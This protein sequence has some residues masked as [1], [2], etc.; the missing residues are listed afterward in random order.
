[1]GNVSN[2]ILSALND[3]ATVDD[4][5]QH[6]LTSLLSTRL[7]ASNYTVTLRVTDDRLVQ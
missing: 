7:F 3:D 5:T 4:T 6:W 1:M 2:A